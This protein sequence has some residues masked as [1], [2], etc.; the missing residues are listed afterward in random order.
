MKRVLFLTQGDI[1]VPSSRHR[2]CLYL[3]FLEKAGFEAVVHPAVTAEEFHDAFIARSWPAMVRRGF[4]TFTRRVKDMHELRDF[5]FV[6]IQKPVLPSPFFNM[7]LRFSQQVKMIF[8]FDDAVFLKK[9]GG[10]LLANWWPQTRRIN[11]ICRHAHQVVVGN[12]F[13]AGFVRKLGI[14][15]VVLPTPVDTEKFAEAGNQLKRPSK[16]PVIGWVGSPSTQDG[17]D[18]LVPSLIDLHSRAPFV[19]RLIGASPS[20]MPVR[21]PIEWKTWKLETEISDIAHFDV[22]LAPMK[23]NEWNRGKCGLKL[24]QYWAAGVPVVASPVGIFREII[25][26]GENGMLASTRAEWTEKILLVMKNSDL[27]NRLVRNGRKTVEEQF[28]LKML[29]PRFLKFFEEPE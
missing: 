15:P 13:L 6:F 3:P 9:P 1:Q 18:L 2:V 22:G 16:I 14:E 27:R 7:E 29:A 5:N 28:S 26:D 20:A 4:Q 10:S 21:F 25:R 19:A 12:E 23:D 8:D 11:S 17:L 24:L